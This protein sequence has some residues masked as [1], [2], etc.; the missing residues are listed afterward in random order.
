MG[1]KTLENPWSRR[2]HS[3]LKASGYCFASFPFSVLGEERK[4][5][6]EPTGKETD[7]ERLQCL[8]TTS[9]NPGGFLR[10]RN[11]SSVSPDPHSTPIP[12]AAPREHGASRLE[13]NGGIPT[14]PPPPRSAQPSIFQ[15]PAI[16]PS[17][18]TPSS[19]SCP[20]FTPTPQH[21]TPCSPSPPAATSP[22]PFPTGSSGRCCPDPSSSPPT[23]WC[24]GGNARSSAACGRWTG[25]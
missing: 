24:G 16:F 1:E 2:N 22:F 9:A 21:T 12:P 23:S 4:E 6:A 3:L 8:W 20:V 14:L 5:P 7:P 11:T 15:S 10:P 19:C 13:R 25:C 17:Q 18:T